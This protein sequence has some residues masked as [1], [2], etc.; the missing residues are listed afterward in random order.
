MG[1]L[2]TFVKGI[3][4]PCAI[5]THATYKALQ[6]AHHMGFTYIILEEDALNAINK[7][8]TPCPSLS[9]IDNLIKDVK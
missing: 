6:F 1:A 2:Q 5:K 3:I 9:N 8:K 4:D 7:I